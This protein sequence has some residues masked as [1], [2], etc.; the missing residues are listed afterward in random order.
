VPDV[1]AHLGG[2]PLQESALYLLP[3]LAVVVWI[4]VLGRR[5]RRR[6]AQEEADPDHEVAE[7]EK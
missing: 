7:S 1:L 3:P 5:E 6:R 2:L 4:Y